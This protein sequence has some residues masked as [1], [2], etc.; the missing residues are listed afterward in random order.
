MQAVSGFVV[1][2]HQIPSRLGLSADQVRDWRNAH[3]VKDQDWAKEGR[4]IRWTEDGVRKLEAFHAV[5]LNPVPPPPTEH[6]AEVTR[7]NFPNTR[8]IE[9]KVEPFNP[10]KV[11]LVRIKPDW[12]D[13]YK[14]KMRIKIFTNSEPI[15]TTRRPRTRY[16]Y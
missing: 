11:Q 4:W 13:L 2:E 7:C 14:P 5:K 12:R 8:I 3:L 9:V 1:L 15:A 16:V 10:G 6:W